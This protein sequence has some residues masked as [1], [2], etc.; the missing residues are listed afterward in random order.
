VEAPDWVYTL[1]TVN[2]GLNSLATVLLISGYVLIK[3]GRRDA[4]RNVMLTAFVTSI[5]FLGCYLTYHF[6]LKHYTGA[7]SQPFQGQ[8]AVRPVYFTILI[9]HVILAAAVPVLAL[10]TIYRGLKQQWEK[11]RRIATITF[12]IWVYVS[13]TGVI[14]YLMLYH[15]PVG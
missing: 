2:A 1:P 7:S 3:R 8:G 4:H 12:P 5:L 14:I 11:H 13:V 6:A 9:T 10:I 15:W